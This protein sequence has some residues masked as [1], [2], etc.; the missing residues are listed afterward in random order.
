[1]A[2]ES[3]NAHYSYCGFCGLP[4]CD[5][6]LFRN[7]KNT[8]LAIF[9][10]LQD[11]VRRPVSYRTNAVG[12]QLLHTKQLN[13]PI[14][15]YNN[16]FL[17]ILIQMFLLFNGIFNLRNAQSGKCHRCSVRWLTSDNVNDD[18][19]E[20]CNNQKCII[21]FNVTHQCMRHYLPLFSEVFIAMPILPYEHCAR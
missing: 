7:G 10:D 16:T 1:M 6:A 4:Q 21:A 20:V 19:T 12:F 14:I 9:E 2:A 13:F 17:L 18:E 15:Q 11:A 3:E 8:R 5:C